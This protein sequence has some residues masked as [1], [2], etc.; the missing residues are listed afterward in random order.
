MQDYKK[1]IIKINEILPKKEKEALVSKEKVEKTQKAL[2][3]MDKK[4]V[5][6]DKAYETQINQLEGLKTL[7][8]NLKKELG[9]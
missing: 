7:E 6:L 9:V 8:E 2:I 5:D 4:L 1:A 3:D